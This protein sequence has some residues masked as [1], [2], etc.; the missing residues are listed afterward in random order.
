MIIFEPAIVK[1]E[2]A[3]RVCTEERRGRKEKRISR[4]GS[5]RRS[6]M[7][8]KQ[9][10]QIGSII[11]TRSSKNPTPTRH[12]IST[13]RVS[14]QAAMKVIVAWRSK[15]CGGRSWWLW[16][17]W[18]GRYG[19]NGS[20]Y[21]SLRTRTTEGTIQRPLVFKRIR[22]PRRWWR[23]RRVLGALRKTRW[24]RW[25]GREREREFL[26]LQGSDDVRDLYKPSNVGK[27]VYTYYHALPPSPF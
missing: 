14:T 2:S 22:K 5:S 13:R 10:T 4:I 26:S 16:S 7:I 17:R 20:T 27:P 23:R 21:P 6:G 15:A 8:W 24:R 1:N 18:C 3:E 12:L 25:E 19:N 9:N 11:S